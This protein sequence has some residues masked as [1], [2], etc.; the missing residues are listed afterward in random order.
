MCQIVDTNLVIVFR[1][2]MIMSI[3]PGGK[4]VLVSRKSPREIFITKS[5]LD[6]MET[7]MGFHPFMDIIIGNIKVIILTILLYIITR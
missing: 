5:G 1:E 7:H 6:I 3:G 4:G 2:L